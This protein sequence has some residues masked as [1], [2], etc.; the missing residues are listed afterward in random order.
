MPAFEGA[1]LER[2]IWYLG[3]FWV[4]VLMN[5]SRPCHFTQRTADLDILQ[6]S[7]D[8]IP[9]DRLTP[10]D[11]KKQPGGLVAVI[12]LVI[13]VVACVVNQLRV[14]RRTGWFF[15][16]LKWCVR[17]PVACPAPW[18]ILSP[19]RRYLVGGAI[20]GI[21]AALPGLEFRLHHYIAA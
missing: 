8:W 10:S 17:V 9:I 2:T 5:V 7:L 14:I 12:C 15:F 1:I 13:F 3:G 21:L 18:L 19:C 16:Y 20:V 6:V 4:G 11:I